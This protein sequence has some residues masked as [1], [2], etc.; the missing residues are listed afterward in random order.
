[1]RQMQFQATD[2]I[3]GLVGFNTGKVINSYATANVTGRDGSVGGLV[4]ENARSAGEISDSYATGTVQISSALTGVGSL[5]GQMGN[6]AKVTNSYTIGKTMWNAPGS[7]NFGIGDLI[8]NHGFSN[9]ASNIARDV[10]HSYWNIDTALQGRSSGGSSK[11]TVELQMP[12]SATGIYREWSTS[13]WDFG[14]ATQYPILKYAKNPGGVKSCGDEGLPECGSVISPEL[15]HDRLNS[16]KVQIEAIG[17]TLSPAFDSDKGD[18]IGTVTKSGHNVHNN[19]QLRV[20]APY[21]NDRIDIYVGSD[22]VLLGKDLTSG[23]IS[24]DITL[25]PGNNLI[26]VEIK[27]DAPAALPFRYKL[28]LIRRDPVKIECLED[29][30]AIRNNLSGNYQLVRDL[31]F[32]DD[33]SYC[34][35]AT[36]KST[37]TTRGAWT[38]IG[39][40]DGDLDCNGAMNS[41]CFTGNFN[42]NGYTISNL[43]INRTAWDYAGLFGAAEG[44]VIGNLGLVDVD[45]HARSILGGVVGYYENGKLYNSYVTGSITL[46]NGNGHNAGGLVGDGRGISIVNSY[47]KITMRAAAGGGLA[48]ALRDGNNEVINSYADMNGTISS[49]GSGLVA[50]VGYRSH[51]E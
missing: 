43:K 17:A 18:Y 41:K 39:D 33:D 22:E 37:W 8:G 13:N 24:K 35:P 25:V 14:T 10:T 45:L 30:N 23:E 36:N 3:G 31:D 2:R 15:R 5:V 12:T 32:D 50:T 34:D 28:N 27:P 48:Y 20:T 44:G 21:L 4:A 7:N 49:S 11:T 26:N 9:N 46:N 29:L 51:Q 6:N 1:M 38:P 19:I 42:G 40:N 16:R 47:A